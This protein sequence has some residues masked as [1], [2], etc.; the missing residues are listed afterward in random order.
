MAGR[1]LFELRA[2]KNQIQDDFLTVG[3]MGHASSIALGVALSQPRRRVICLDGDG[4][5]IM[6]MGAIPIIGDLKPKKFVHILLN[7]A[8]HDSVGGQPTVGGKIDIG[9]L[10]TSCGYKFY[11]KAFSQEEIIKNWKKIILNDG[12]SMLEI[13]VGK[14]ARKDLGRPTSTPVENKTRFMKKLSNY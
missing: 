3:G 14:G 12:P 10:V 2:K 11:Y 9:L 8:A 5:L 13:V 7:N 6:H 1:E 4:A